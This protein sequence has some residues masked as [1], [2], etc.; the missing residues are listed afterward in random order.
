MSRRSPLTKSPL[1]APAAPVLLSLIATLALGC[2]ARDQLPNAA[3]AGACAA[4]VLAS[5]ATVAEVC[6]PGACAAEVVDTSGTTYRMECDGARC[7]LF[8][9][10]EPVCDCDE[11][12]SANT[13]S[14][15]VPACFGKFGLPAAQLEPCKG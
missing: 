7:T 10:G 11:P 14:N 13:C 8:A 5:N 12:D 6:M 3:P 15:G 1:R 9:A 2:G 4:P